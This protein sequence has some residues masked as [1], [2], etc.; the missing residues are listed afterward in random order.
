VPAGKQKN[1]MGGLSGIGRLVDY[2]SDGE[3][4]MQRILNLYPVLVE[5]QR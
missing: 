5:E 4:T 3:G 2:F 1:E